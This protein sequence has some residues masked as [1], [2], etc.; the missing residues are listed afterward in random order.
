[1]HQFILSPSTWLGEGKIQLSMVEEDL[2]FYTKWRIAQKDEGGK[3]EC[4]QEIQV[5]GL[6]EIM[7]NQFLI[8]D[9]TP[10]AFSVELDNPAIGKISGKG[11]ITDKLIAWEFRSMQTGF[12]GFEFY[13]RQ[14]DDSYL[15]HAEYATA[16]QLRTVIKGKVWQDTSKK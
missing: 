11:L 8:S 10:G 6:S 4:I 7:L 15:M 14:A 13:E 9:L 12:D 1:M 16:D 5:K 3:I 2:P